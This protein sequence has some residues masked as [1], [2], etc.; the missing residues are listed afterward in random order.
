MWEGVLDTVYTDMPQHG[1]DTTVDVLQSPPDVQL[2]F[3]RWFQDI[4]AMTTNSSLEI[5]S[6]VLNSEMF[7]KV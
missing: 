3:A 1:K 5:R 6:V 7:I 2:E 4:I